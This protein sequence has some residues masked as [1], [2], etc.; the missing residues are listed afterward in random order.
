M[1]L[2]YSQPFF[3][4]VPLGEVIDVCADALYRNDDIDPVITTLTGDSFR[5]LL[6]LVTSEVEFSFNREMYRQINGV[7]MGS[8][9]GQTLENI[10]VDFYEKKI[11][12]NEWPRMYHRYVDD[13]FSYFNN[14]ESSVVFFERL[15]NLHPALRFTL[16]SEEDGSLPF[17]GVRVTRGTVGIITSLPQADLHRS[18]LPVGFL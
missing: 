4:N 1:F 12:E 17:M 15:N 13:I 16:E 11:P 18:V 14:Q 9:L 5:E 8:P 6:R 3:T 7:A 10:F 2:R